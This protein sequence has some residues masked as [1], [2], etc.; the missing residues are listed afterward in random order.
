MAIKGVLL[1]NEFEFNEHL[2]FLTERFFRNLFLFEAAFFS[3][4]SQL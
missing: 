3:L 1:L 4:F 2:V